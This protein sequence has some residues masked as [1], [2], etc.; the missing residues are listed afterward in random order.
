MS[1]YDS[2]NKKKKQ[3]SAAQTSAA[4]AASA[5]TAPKGTFYQQATAKQSVRANVQ[6]TAA[7]SQNVPESARKKKS[8]IESIYKWYSGD[9]PT[10]REMIAQ[11]SRISGD[12]RE[13]F[14][15]YMAQYAEAAQEKGSPLYNPYFQATNQKAIQ[16][17]A[18]LGVDVSGGINQAFFD[19]NIGYRNYDRTVTGDTPLAPSKK[20]S[21]EQD[22]AYWLYKLQQ[23]EETTVAAENELKAM[24]DEIGYWVSKGYSDNEVLAKIDMSNYKTLAKMDEGRMSGTPIGLNRAVNW[25]DD[26]KYGMLWAARNGDTSGDYLAGA[27]QYA[28]GR[29]KKY[30]PDAKSEAARDVSSYETYDPYSN[31]ATMDDARKYTDQSRFDRKWLDANRGLLADEEGAKVWES[32]SKAVDN[33]EAAQEELAKLMEYV[34]EQIARGKEPEEVLK[35]IDLEKNY[36]TLAK[37]EDYRV[38]GGALEL[39]DSV[40]FTWPKFQQYVL[41]ARGNAA[42]M[43]GNAMA[44]ALAGVT[45]ARMD[46]YDTLDLNASQA[47]S[48]QAAN[49]QTAR[50]VTSIADYLKGYGTEDEQAQEWLDK[51]GYLVSGSN[52]SQNVSA[53][54][55]M[56][57]TVIDERYKAGKDALA[58]L[59]LADEA[60][61]SATD[62][63]ALAF[64]VGRDMEQ[65]EKLGMKPDKYYASEQGA[66]AK[67]ELDAVA[68]DLRGVIAQ[69]E[70][71]AASA[72]QAQRDAAMDVLTRADAGEV[73]TEEEQQYHDYVRSLDVDA[74]MDTDAGVR[75]LTK[76]VASI[77]E[78]WNPPVEG[79]NG[80]AAGEVLNTISL[81]A[82]SYTK[83]DMQNAAA[84]GMDYEEYAAAYPERVMSAP[85]LVRR[86][87]DEFNSVWKSYGNDLSSKLMAVDTIG[88]QLQ[89]PG[90][91]Q[92]EGVEYGEGVGKLTA[93]GK[94]VQ[95][96]WE[97][98]LYSTADWIDYFFLSGTQEQTEAAMRSLYGN[99]PAA[100]RAAVEESVA[101]LA[102]EDEKAYWTEQLAGNADVFS[103]GYNTSTDGVQQFMYERK[104]AIQKIEKYM[105]ENGTH[106]ENLMMSFTS[107]ATDNALRLTESMLLNAVTGGQGGTAVNLARTT[108]VYGLSEGAQMGRELEESG[109]DPA[110]ARAFGMAN[111]I[112]TGVS[113]NLVEVNYLPASMRGTRKTL[114]LKGAQQLAGENPSLFAKLTAKGVQVIAGAAEEGTQEVVQSL[115]TTTIKDVAVASM[116]DAVYAPSYDGSALATDFV[117]GALMSP[118]LNVVGMTGSIPGKAVSSAKYLIEK[119][120]ESKAA[121]ANANVA[122]GLEAEGMTEGI[123]EEEPQQREADKP[124]QPVDMNEAPAPAETELPKQAEAPAPERVSPQLESLIQLYDETD[125]AAAEAMREIL[126]LFESEGFQ[127]QLNE[128]ER[129]AAIEK[130]TVEILTGNGQVN[131]AMASDPAITEAAQGVEEAAAAY[132]QARV[133]L[134]RL[135]A[136]KAAADEALANAQAAFFEQPSDDLLR[137]QYEAAVGKQRTTAAQYAEAQTEAQAAQLELAEA[138]AAQS[139]AEKFIL[140]GFRAEARAQAEAEVAQAMQFRETEIAAEQELRAQ[141][142]A[143]E[144]IELFADEGAKERAKL[145]A[146]VRYSQLQEAQIRGRMYRSPASDETTARFRERDAQRLSEVQQS[147]MAAEARIAQIDAAQQAQAEA[148]APSPIMFNEE[149]VSYARAGATGKAVSREE[150]RQQ[151]APK[152]G[153][154]LANPIGIA[155]SLAKALGV[156]EY[157][158]TNRG[159]PDGALGLYHHIAGFFATDPQNASNYNVSMHEIGHALSDRLHMTGTSAMVSALPAATRA[160]YPSTAWPGEAFA[161]FVSYYMQSRDAARRFAGADYVRSFESALRE[162]GLYKTVQEHADALRYWINAGTDA[163]IDSMIVNTAEA[164]IP[165]RMDL[166]SITERFIIDMVD[167]SRA[168]ADVDTRLRNNETEHASLREA[169]LF[170]AYNVRMAENCIMN[171]LTDPEGNP[172]GIGFAEAI[173][174]E[175]R[176]SDIPSR[177]IP[178]MLNRFMLARHGLDRLS[179]GKPL[180]GGDLDA[181]VLEEYVNDVQRNHPEIV[182]AADA[183][184]NWYNSFYKVWLVNTG[185]VSQQTFDHFTTMYPHYVPTFRNIAGDKGSNAMAKTAGTFRMRG[186]VEGG[187]D[188][189]IINPVESM[190]N[191]TTKIVNT[192]ARNRV[193]RVFDQLYDLGGLGVFARRI[194]ST[195]AD[196]I[197]QANR[198]A[199]EMEQ[200]RQRG[201]D[202]PE[203]IHMVDALASE[204]AQA[205]N[206][207][208]VALPDG[209]VHSYEFHDMD[210]FNALAA[211]SPMNAQT[212]LELLGKMT[213]TMSALTTGENPLFGPRNFM[214]D[215]Q[216]AVNYG[217]FA[218]TYLDGLYKWVKA[219]ID[220]LRDSEDHQQYINLGGGEYGMLNSGKAKNAR[221]LRKGIFNRKV[222]RS[223]ESRQKVKVIDV[224]TF[225][226]QYSE[227]VTRFAEYKYGKHDLSTA[228]GRISAFMAAQDVT[229]DFARGGSSQTFKALRQIMPFVNPAIQ[230]TYRTA[231]MFSRAEFDRLPA[232]F[233]KTVFNKGL[234]AAFQVLMLGGAKSILKNLGW[235]MDDDEYEEIRRDYELVA[236]DVRASNLLIPLGGGPRAF[237]RIPLEEDILGKAIYAAALET[238]SSAAGNDE[239]S[240]NLMS[241]AARLL[242]DTVPN[243]KTGTILSPI[244]SIYSNKAWHGGEIVSGSL[245]EEY[246]TNQYNESTPA[247]FVNTSRFLD[248]ATKGAVQLAPLHLQYLAEQYAG[249]IG[250]LAIP[251]MSS[252]KYTGEWSLMY[253]LNNVLASTKNTFTIDPA[254]T[255]DATD[256]YY[257]GR[258]TLDQIVKA[259][260]SGKSMDMLSY[261]IDEFVAADAY[262]EAYAMTH[263]GG[264]F[265]ETKKEISEVYNE[266]AEINQREDLS[267]GDKERMTRE[268]R[269]RIVELEQDALAEYDEFCARYKNGAYLDSVL[270]VFKGKRVTVDQ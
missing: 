246:V 113:E 26:T 50:I 40:N 47:G 14:N 202:V 48:E 179:A 151:G 51:Y 131:E 128:Q 114:A 200:A 129:E 82:M 154:R 206:I 190:V 192:V 152:K 224:L 185:L 2:Y 61:L 159:M 178:D 239:F 232:R 196:Y 163:K 10:G 268:Q 20:S 252:D 181:D 41:N 130:R 121:K 241:Y 9:R 238:Y 266:I 147:R 99:D 229:V 149:G 230:G 254:Y 124:E 92:Q 240:I 211:T 215:F 180:F 31:G 81:L 158:G 62:Q 112:W 54:G 18:E 118:L 161:E 96:G 250:D 39:T 78:N 84:L 183:A 139:E 32:V 228:E 22:I 34:N 197:T 17:L 169:V 243:F 134:D 106:G 90:L 216:N 45:G 28:L 166:R 42:E 168:A 187:S 58:V 175:L 63:A 108:M 111:A 213:R 237:I 157:Q 56:M 70:A 235:S 245:Q 155:Q 71:D 1:W 270:N 267:Y 209:S 146:D 101:G 12:D 30:E 231:R 138:Q 23:D 160:A 80:M 162:A 257:A 236:E 176:D 107:A 103:L 88:A 115:G 85:E 221:E 79:E 76:E 263:A 174:R 195:Q 256:A 60:N 143:A 264:I 105:Q 223:G 19:A 46:Y 140:D 123:T 8:D 212:G 5:S 242:G 15:G 75:A 182:R 248:A 52:I 233:A 207:L 219:G 244:A 109:V 191:L 184:T 247:M 77:T 170:R 59:K 64:K 94:G 93:V 171:T 164:N 225:F 261:D 150:S 173:N 167:A 259:G 253:G 74:I 145:E 25:N 194:P 16:A 251:F 43:T 110:A 55:G 165:D 133:V 33:T 49:N 57:P 29:G 201:E 205:G 153:K 91:A 189:E 222:T 136:G 265:Y 208:N 67:A 141:Y 72:Q 66:A 117:M 127:A 120:A 269:M 177:Q 4:P 188:L 116:T 255:N 217:S 132:E 220:V 37:M 148:E 226:N 100:Y 102:D 11:I 98:H 193:G 21:N 135:S 89:E 186:A 234:Q 260:D 262:E 126:N 172:V 13:M 38:R 156:G 6:K 65:A 73:L 35:K 97:S 227:E 119:F 142:E 122:A 144:N 218:I 214:K 86:A 44:S 104:Q 203:F 198:R 83:E 87:T 258:N 68:E 199:D 95:H 3:P 69:N 53:S 204:G 210:L 7:Q 137:R 249:W 27:V 36:K 24:A 125:P